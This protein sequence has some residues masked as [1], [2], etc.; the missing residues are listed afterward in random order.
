MREALDFAYNVSL[1]GKLADNMQHMTSR[2]EQTA[3]IVGL[4]I[5][6]G[7]RKIM[8]IADENRKKVMIDQGQIE[9]SNF[10]Y[11][12][13]LMTNNGGVD[14]DVNGRMGK[15]SAVFGQLQKTLNYIGAA[16]ISVMP[17]PIY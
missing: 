17:Q 3:S 13:S 8:R 14:V 5:S 6:V 7:K 9:V 16:K 2:V 10:A 15:A 1:L 11:L 12:V 4:Q